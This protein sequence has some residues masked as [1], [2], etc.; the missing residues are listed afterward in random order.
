MKFATLSVAA[1]R[2]LGREVVNS[3]ASASRAS[4]AWIVVGLMSLGAWHHDALGAE[5]AAPGPGFVVRHARV[6]DGSTVRADTDVLVS[7]GRIVAVGSNLAVPE[8]TA[9]VDGHGRSLL[10]GLIDAHVHA[11]GSAQ[12]DAIRFGVTTELDMFSDWHQIAAAVTQRQSLAP[13]A[14][15]DLW[16]AGTLATVPHGHGTNTASRS[17]R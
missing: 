4:M 11:Y 5:P 16:S 12:R 1:G 8:G 9:I 3:H 2:C 14:Q 15:A 7:G 13:T 6:I 17:R 10:P